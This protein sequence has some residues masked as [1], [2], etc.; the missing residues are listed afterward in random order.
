[1]SSEG[2]T[3]RQTVTEAKRKDDARK[4]TKKDLDKRIKSFYRETTAM[5]VDPETA[6]LEVCPECHAR[7]L[8]PCVTHS[9]RKAPAPH[10]KRLNARDDRRAR[11]YEK[12]NWKKIKARRAS[13][14][15]RREKREKNPT[16]NPHKER[17]KHESAR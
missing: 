8:C 17:F 16:G 5:S 14:A 7:P 10:P 2:R 15:I 9:G 1:M 11:M 4:K 12:E 13:N 3:F 6:I